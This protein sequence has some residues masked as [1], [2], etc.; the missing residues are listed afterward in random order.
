MKK[1]V[2]TGGTSFIG[3]HLCHCFLDE[4][5]EIYAII[6]PDSP[7]RKYLTEQKNIHIIELDIANID[8]A[9]DYIQAADV[10][11]HFAWEGVN[12]NDI[13]NDLLHQQNVSYALRCA[14]TAIALGCR[15]FI[16]SGSRAEYGRCDA[17]MTEELPC[18]PVTAYGKSKL[19]FYQKAEK[20]FSKHAVTYY[21]L[22]I[23]SV[24]GI[25]D[26]PW[27]LISTLT[28]K[29]YQGETVNLS[30]CLHTWNFMHV[31]DAAHAIYLLT[32][33]GMALADT[34]HEIVNI[35]GSDNRVLYDF[36]HEVHRCVGEKGI[37]TFGNFH[38]GKEKSLSVAADNSKMLNLLN[39]Y[40]ENYSFEEGIK[41][42]ITYLSQNN[43]ET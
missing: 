30:T 29:L 37:L 33:R 28:S 11:I 36:V 18:N 39:G 13:D 3:R 25:G 9:T 5:W 4:Q 32:K 7:N 23:F 8:K 19:A 17:P 43:K 40:T 41:E 24:Y 31:K 34:E 6:R 35:A 15:V 22:R 12:R 1:L 38:Q 20:L 10:F 26:H 42:I 16:D 21:H 27:S 14:E 2:I